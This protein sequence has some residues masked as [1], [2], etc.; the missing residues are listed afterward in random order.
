MQRFSDADRSSEKPNQRQVFAANHV[1]R[2]GRRSKNRRIRHRIRRMASILRRTIT[3]PNG[4]HGSIEMTDNLG[5]RSEVSR[6]SLMS[7]CREFL[8]NS[9]LLEGSFSS[10]LSDRGLRL[11]VADL[12]TTVETGLIRPHF[13]S[14]SAQPQ[15]HPFRILPV[16]KIIKCRMLECADTAQKDKSTIE[17]YNL[18]S[19]LAI[20][21]EPVYWPIIVGKQSLRRTGEDFLSELESYREQVREYI[22]SLDLV[23]WKRHHDTLRSE[24][25]RIDRNG[26]LYVLLR[27]S[28]WESR[29]RLKGVVSLALWIRHLAEVIRLGFEEVHKTRWDE[30]DHYFGLLPSKSRL[31]FFGSTR[32]F[33]N[34]LKTRPYIVKFFGLQT[35]AVRWYVEGTTEYYAIQAILNDVAS[36][37]IELVDLRGNISQESD[38]IAMKLRERLKEDQQFRRFS[39]ITFDQ[40]VKQNVKLVRMLIK[41]ELIVGHISANKPDFELANFTIPEL[42]SA[43]SKM[44]D[45][46]SKTDVGMTNLMEI[47][48]TEIRCARDLETIY[49]RLGGGSLKGREWGEVLAARLLKRTTRPDNGLERPLWRQ[50]LAAIRARSVNYD[51]QK[52][53][54]TFDPDTFESI[55]RASPSEKD[56]R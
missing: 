23:T 17:R 7:T 51:F 33:D 38:N 47:D 28:N 42:L 3:Q 41:E 5:D 46:E 26:E 54:N 12:K 14:Y 45:A 39:F 43:S 48:R 2:A 53:K 20:L 35:F 9:P 36:S 6:F 34:P 44:L 24:G 25:D 56:N 21:M 10:F 32:A 8:Q 30:E 19:D 18:I 52:S 11:S 27:V 29:E 49:E 40:D 31:R 1:L 50:V 55:R 15:F 37:G 22:Q 13:Q 4:H 16:W